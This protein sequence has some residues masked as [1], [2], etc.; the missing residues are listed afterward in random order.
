MQEL[1][2]IAQDLSLLESK[3]TE[4][5]TALKTISANPA[6]FPGEAVPALFAFLEAEDEDVIDATIAA[7]EALDAKIPTLDAEMMTRG[8][9]SG[10]DRIVELVLRQLERMDSFPDELSVL[11]LISRSGLSGAL[12]S[13]LSK[14]PQL[15][16]RPNAELS[17]ILRDPVTALAFLDLVPN[18]AGA[19]AWLDECFAHLTP[20]DILVYSA[21][22]ETLSTNLTPSILSVFEKDGILEKLAHDLKTVKRN[23][24]PALLH[25]FT[26]VAIVDPKQFDKLNDTHHVLKTCKERWDDAPTALLAMLCDLSTVDT[27]LVELFL[28]ECHS[29]FESASGASKVDYLIALDAFMQRSTLRDS[30][31]IQL[32]KILPGI[33]APETRLISLQLFRHAADSPA[34]AQ[35]MISHPGFVDAIVKRDE[36]D[37][38]AKKARFA[39]VCA[40]L[41][42]GNPSGHLSAALLKYKLD[43]VSPSEPTLMFAPS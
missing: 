24:L 21:M 12:A 22:V 26:R 2:A 1:I 13:V 7:L 19:E 38:D 36:Q 10:D 5:L 11:P 23:Q 30:L 41:D 32:N 43:G 6:N 25:L 15:I 14:H 37:L 8:L 4:V 39:L 27:K 29:R 33:Y 16:A 31:S 20:N 17:A 18:V 40:L 28:P 34:L 35:Q 9:Q 3:K 42:K